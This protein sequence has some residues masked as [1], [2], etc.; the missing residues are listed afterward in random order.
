MKLDLTG[1]ETFVALADERHFGRTATALGV[2]V[3]TVTKRLHRLEADLG[4]PLILRGPTGVAGLTPAGERFL[5]VAPTL[6]RA[7]ATAREAALGE[8]T[9]ELRVAIPAGLEAV[10]PL[11]PAALGTLELALRHEHAGVAVLAAPTPFDR[12][13]DDLLAGDVDAV[14]T[15]GPSPNAAV[16]STRLAPLHRVGLVA[17]THPLARRRSVPVEEFA[18]LP[19]IYSPGLPGHY[20]RQFVLADVRPLAEATLVPIQ[21]STTAHVAQ[22]LLHGSEATVVPLALTG[23]LPP[24]LT[25]IAL[26]GVPPSWYWSHHRADDDRPMLRTAIELMGD[27]TASI[28]RAAAHGLA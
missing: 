23:N 5:A 20:M 9:A 14:L 21:A 17:S 7:A 8:P 24:E 12:L 1:V 27:F 4:I 28:S 16:A 18:R 19:L 3:P 15:F 25:R 11:V 22:R 6:V 26:T 2:S 10:A 13:T